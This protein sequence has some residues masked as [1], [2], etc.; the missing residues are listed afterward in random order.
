MKDLDKFPTMEKRFRLR[1]RS[2]GDKDGIASYR[3]T[4]SDEGGGKPITRVESSCASFIE[5]PW[6]KSVGQGQ[7]RV[8]RQNLVEAANGKG[9]SRK[10]ENLHQALIVQKES[11][12][13]KYKEKGTMVD[14]AKTSCVKNSLQKLDQ[15]H[16]PRKEVDKNMNEKKWLSKCGKQ[17]EGKESGK[18][19]EGKEVKG[20]FLSIGG[21]EK[22]DR[23]KKDKEEIDRKNRS[24]QS[25][26]R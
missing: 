8:N 18:Q 4:V 19:A 16:K 6:C 17:M 12:T 5:K 9:V 20:H 25:K 24:K 7:T 15:I 21:R 1:G 11:C 23:M 26:L 14:E 10:C 22:R 13:C 2:L 3:L